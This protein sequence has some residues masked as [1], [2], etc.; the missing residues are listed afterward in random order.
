MKQA[1]IAIL[2]IGLLITIF[3]GIKFITKEKVLD[4]GGLEITRDKKHNLAW[5]PLIGIAV[6]AIGGG[7]Y[8]FGSK[9]N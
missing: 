5:S 1:G 9:K 2:I 3:T 6:M 7:M 4:I 8:L